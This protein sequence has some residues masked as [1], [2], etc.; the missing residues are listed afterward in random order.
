MGAGGGRH[1]WVRSVDP[2]CGVGVQTECRNAYTLQAECQTQACLEAQSGK[3]CSFIED[4]EPEDCLKDA[5]T[6]SKRKADS[7]SD[8]KPAKRPRATETVSNRRPS[9]AIKYLRD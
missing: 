1:P 9:A 6:A 2:A 7:H 8:T 3:V 4:S 5:A